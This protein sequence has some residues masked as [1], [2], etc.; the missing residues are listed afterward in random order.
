[1]EQQLEI[2][3]LEFGLSQLSG[4]RSLLIKLFGKFSMEYQGLPEKLVEMNAQENMSA[5]KQA[6][7]T[8]KGV[9]GNLGLN[10]LHQAA[11]GLE[12]AVISGENI[13][14][15]Y[16]HFN[17]ILAE[18]LAQIK[19]LSAEPESETNETQ[20]QSSGK[21]GLNELIGMLKRNQFI[22][23]DEL[24]ELLTQCD[25][26][27]SIKQDLSSAISD[28]DYPLALSLLAQD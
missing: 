2:I 26:S 19:L 16:Q 14:S 3:N 23:P 6:V 28:L 21:N 13:D 9:S 27:E 8:I 17:A 25:V 7:H 12:S 18:T 24:A 20:S 11:K 5:Y 4:N 22:P 15:S 1:M 10:A